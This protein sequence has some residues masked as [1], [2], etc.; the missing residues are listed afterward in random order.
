MLS[1]SSQPRFL[2]PPCEGGH[3]NLFVQNGPLFVVCL[4]GFWV[5]FF[6]KHCRSLGGKIKRGMTLAFQNALLTEISV[7]DTALFFICAENVVWWPSWVSNLRRGSVP[8]P[9]FVPSFFLEAREELCHS[10]QA[11]WTPCV[12]REWRNFSPLVSQG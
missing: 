1:F 10:L 3:G 11:E 7:L 12:P 4:L 9:S 5:G 2:C 8:C 6:F